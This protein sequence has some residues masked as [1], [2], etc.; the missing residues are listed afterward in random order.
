LLELRLKRK[1]KAWTCIIGHT[2]V[3]ARAH[4]C[5][6]VHLKKDTIPGPRSCNMFIG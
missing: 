1:I 2:F 5:L 6:P 3:F 4:L